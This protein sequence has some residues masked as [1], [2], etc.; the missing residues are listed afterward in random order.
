MGNARARFGKADVERAL[1]AA[2]A[3]GCKPSGFTVAADGAIKVEFEG[4]QRSAVHNP[5]DRVFD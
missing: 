2:V 5:L 3:A 1:R 4:P